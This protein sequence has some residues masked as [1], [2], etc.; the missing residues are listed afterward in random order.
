MKRDIADLAVATP[1]SGVAA[2]PPSV[3]LVFLAILGTFAW[4]LG[5]FAPTALEIGS[6]W[7][8][9]DTYAHGLI[10]LP[11]FVGLVW[12]NRHRLAGHALQP[13]AVWALAAALAGAGWLLG[14]VASVAAATH[15]FLVAL[16]VAT[17]AGVLGPA[18][19]RPLLFP[20]LFLFFGVPIGDFMLPTLMSYTADV[21]VWALRVSGIPVYQE[22]L[23]FVVPNGRWSVVEACSGIRYLIA[24]LTVGALYAYL[25]YRSLKR[26][27][28]F[29]LVALLVPI[30]A[31]WA[32]AYM[33]VL[34]GYL[35]DNRLA[36]GVDHLIYGWVF[37]GV[38]IFLMFGIGNRWHEPAAAVVAGPVVPAPSSPRRWLALLPLLAVAPLFHTA[39]SVLTRPV[40][41]F[42]LTLTLPPAAEGWSSAAGREGVI[43]RPSYSGQ[44]AEAVAT[45]RPPQGLPV[46]LYVAV[47]ADQGEGAEMVTW[48]NGLAQPGSHQVL[49]MQ[50]SPA[51]SGGRSYRRATVSAEGERVRVWQTYLFDGRSVTN[52]IELKLRLAAARLSGRAD[53]SA[54]VIAMAPEGDD[55]GAD[56]AIAALLAQYQDGIVTAIRQAE[57]AR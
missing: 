26:R 42:A 4:T 8:R 52:D 25:S 40:A 2:T 46:T 7:R 10:V 32:R 19:M 20:V 35:S 11:V 34:L 50:R 28:M 12:R 27:L 6:I 39:E 41:P 1:P 3:A 36:A 45:Y 33:I 43:Y 48:G 22:G 15:F 29:M 31:N 18:L 57:R 37:F 44:R 47:F 9:S 17:L 51:E 24:S 21:T 54:V 5:W 14:Q 56:E 30:V 23:H 53:L 49:V 55:N 16:L 13:R 38:V